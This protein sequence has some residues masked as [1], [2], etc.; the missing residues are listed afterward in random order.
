MTS[1]RKPVNQGLRVKKHQVK[2]EYGVIY[3]LKETCEIDIG[4]FRKN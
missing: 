2:G 1:L 4:I 3:G